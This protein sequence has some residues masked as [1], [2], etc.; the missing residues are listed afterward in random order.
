MQTSEMMEGANIPCKSDSYGDNFIKYKRFLP[1]FPKELL[2][3]PWHL[4]PKSAREGLLV[5]QKFYKQF[6]LNWLVNAH[7]KQVLIQNNE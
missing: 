5:R 4:L 7:S 3:R 2:I 6:S 1:P